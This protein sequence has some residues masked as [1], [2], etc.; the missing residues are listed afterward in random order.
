[1]EVKITNAILF[2]QA[3][4]NLLILGATLSILT[5]ENDRK[6]EAHKINKEKFLQGK[7]F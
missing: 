2:K 5:T 3:D 6:D 4:R 1:M 7:N